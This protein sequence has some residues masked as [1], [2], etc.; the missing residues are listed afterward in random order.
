MPRIAIPTPNSDAE[1]SARI[2][3]Q[4]AAAVECAGGIAVEIPLGLGNAGTAQLIKS[5]DGVL[6]PG[7]PADVD[8]QKYGAALHRATAAADSPRENVDELL[9]QDAFNMRKPILGICFGAQMLNVW[10]QGTLV[11]HIESPVK[12]TRSDDEPRGTKVEHRVIV[13]AGS[14]LA[15]IVGAHLQSEPNTLVLETNSSH[16]QAVEIPGDRLF[17]S[18]RADGDGVIEC[19]EGRDTNHFV[20]GVQWHPERTYQNDAASLELFRALVKAAVSWHKAAKVP[21]D[22]ETAGMGISDLR[23]KISD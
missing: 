13:E 16:H 23:S 15:K 9:L 2:W 14:R 3:K 5:C 12:H 22:F 1:Y 6:L 19:V 8:P 18:A 10:L 21:G 11:Q 17:I 20:L 7:S 4:Y